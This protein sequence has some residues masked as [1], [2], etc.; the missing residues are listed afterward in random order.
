MSTVEQ[1]ADQ[2]LRPQIEAAREKGYLD[3]DPEH[4]EIACPC[5]HRGEPLAVIRFSQW[6]EAPGDYDLA[7]CPECGD[8]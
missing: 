7:I 4:Y 1:A 6:E 2:H 8:A 5:G 3:E